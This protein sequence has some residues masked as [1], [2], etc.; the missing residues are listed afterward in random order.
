[1]KGCG[2]CPLWSKAGGGAE[3]RATSVTKAI[4]IASLELGDHKFARRENAMG[5]FLG[6]SEAAIFN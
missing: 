6:F 5:S 2:I 1:M 4:G 3:L